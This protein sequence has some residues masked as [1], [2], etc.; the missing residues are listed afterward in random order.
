MIPRGA[1][2]VAGLLALAAP[3]PAPT[4]LGLT[5]TGAGLVALWYSVDSPGSGG[6]AVLIALAAVSWLATSADHHHTLRLVT[7]ALAVAVVHSSAALAAVVP[8]RAA[9][10]AALLLRWAG[11][12]V[13]APALGA[14]ALAAASLLTAPDVGAP[15]TVATAT[16]VL[17]LGALG[18][19]AARLGLRRFPPAD[20]EADRSPVG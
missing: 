15:V 2:A 14:G 19:G 7:L 3:L 13:L 12:T 20:A 8:V 6:P 9:L 4:I 5:V 17:A 11:W 16:A 1:L 10:P 18:A